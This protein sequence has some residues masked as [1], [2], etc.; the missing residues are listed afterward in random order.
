MEFA[1]AIVNTVAFIILSFITVED[2]KSTSRKQRFDI[3]VIFVVVFTWFR[4]F[5]YFLVI[6]GL[7]RHFITIYKMVKQTI[8]FMI[9]VLSVL[10]FE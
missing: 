6:K 1:T 3:L 4:F 10:L 2:I 9:V 5:S 8:A 7:S